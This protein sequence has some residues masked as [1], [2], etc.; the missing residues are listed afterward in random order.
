M[1]H[2]VP[3]ARAPFPMIRHLSVRTTPWLAATPLSANHVTTLSLAFGLA[4][5]AL[6]ASGERGLAIVGALLLVVSY[7]L[8]NCDGE[9]ARQKQQTSEFGAFYDTF[10]DFVV[11]TSLFLA[12]GL[13]AEQARGGSLWLWL[14]G[15]AAFGST[16]NYLLSVRRDLRARARRAEASGEAAAETPRQP[17]SWLDWT[18][19]FFRE[20]SRADFCFL[21]LALAIL[22]ATWILLPAG[23]IGAQVYW[24]MSFVRGA[25]DYHV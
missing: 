11:H 13:G 14:A 23:A 3:A 16:L 17:E 12:L 19:F 10:A 24:A 8:D 21:I 22:D 25:E 5:N 2:D 15:L 4:C 20:L 1:T 18:V 7:V 9:L 6:L